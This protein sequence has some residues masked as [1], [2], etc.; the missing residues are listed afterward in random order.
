MIHGY[1]FLTNNNRDRN[2]HGPEF[3]KHMNRINT[4]AGTK[5]TVCLQSK[6]INVVC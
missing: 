3:C 1:L 4:A 5:I 6:I 2:G